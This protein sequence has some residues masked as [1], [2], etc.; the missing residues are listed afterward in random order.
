MIKTALVIIANGSEE[1]EAITVIDILRRGGVNVSIAGETDIVHCSNG[2]KILPDIS[3]H[4]VKESVIYDLIY[5][6]GGSKGV[7]ILIE[8]EKVTEI[9][10]NHNNA[11]KYIAAICAAPTILDFQGILHI[12]AKV[13]S[14]PSVSHTLKRFNYSEDMIVESGNIITSRGAGT[15]L[16]FALFL[17]EKLVGNAIIDKIK[18]DIVYFQDI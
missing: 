14:H 18:S 8:N 6:P 7:E 2:V 4:K 9:L 16:P 11:G 10:N 3:L 1:L 17:A 12:D 15:A 13:T 5:L